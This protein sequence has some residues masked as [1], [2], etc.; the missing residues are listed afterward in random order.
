M[1]NTSASGGYLSPVG[2]A[3]AD[4]L[5]LDVLL[6]DAV[7]GVTGLPGAMVRPRWQP[8][9]P[10][11]PEPAENWCAIGVTDEQPENTPSIEHDPAANG[12][13]VMTRHP[14]FEVL[15]SFYGPAS[16]HYA[17]LLRDGL[18]IPQN[19]E[20]LRTAGIALVSIGATIS[21]PDLVNQ[22]WIR[23]K[24][25]RITLRRVI[26][27]TYPVLNILSAE[28]VGHTASGPELDIPINP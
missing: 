5:E 15:A 23:R 10:R 22:Q 20:T 18:Y 7:V 13:D 17:A 21:A 9:T 19:R 1:P 14:V 8:V 4:D 25:V 2:A 28:V 11:Q 6:Q 27:R 24:D 16:G 26:V 12:P 3:P